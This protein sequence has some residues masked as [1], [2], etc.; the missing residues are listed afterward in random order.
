MAISA[1]TF[2]FSA[3]DWKFCVYYRDFAVVLRNKDS[4]LLKVMKKQKYS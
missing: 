3:I 2:F 4:R 1:L